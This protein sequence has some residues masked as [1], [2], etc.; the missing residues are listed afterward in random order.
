MTATFRTF[1]FV[2][3]VFIS[4]VSPNAFAADPAAATEGQ[5][6]LEK[7]KTILSSLIEQT[8]KERGVPSISIALVR[9]D[10]IVWK[11]AFGY[12]NVRTKTPA[13]PETMYN[14][15]STFKAVTATAI[16]QLAE[17]GKFNLDDPVNRYLG[18]TP[19][20]DRIQSEKPVT[21]THVLSHWSGLT[22]WP[23]R[24]EA[25]MKSVWASEVP[26]TLEQ[27]IPELYS[28]RPPEAK[29][30][31]NN[32]GYGLA[33][34]LLER[35]S[36]LQYE[37]YITEHVFKPLGVTTPHPVYPSPEMVEL[38]ALPYD[39]A[40]SGTEPH[41]APQVHTQVYPAGNAY[42][43]P[44]G[45]A[46]FLGAHINGGVFQGQR[47]LSPTSVKQ[48]HEPRFGGNYGFGFRIKKTPGGSTL[49][50]HT[51]RLPG[52]SSMMLGDVDAHVGVYYMANAT[53][54]AA[55]IADAA[56]VLLRGE[57]YPVEDRKF[58]EVDTKVLERYVGSYQAGQNVFTI[59][60][61]GE[62]LVVQKNNNKKKG[63]LLA[64]TPTSFFL[65]GDPATLTFETNS[66]RVV[67]RMVIFEADW[68]LTS[69]NRR[70]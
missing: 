50:R 27:L 18:D 44:E 64:E 45:M 29:F 26:R 6:D 4:T 65:K 58:I 61:E 49:I 42:L 40:E 30:E 19:V 34:L 25:A 10:S 1:V 7:T 60:R 13:T 39:L 32:Y 16:M 67:D 41:P 54:V 2:A 9:G 22:S 3:I 53:D 17:Q 47:I 69:A 62:N 68:Q 63:T 38:M 70:K 51:G 37:K 5:F 57:T 43:P 11:A 23:G 21:F 15:A 12:A 14:A 66:S 35:I 33:G 20:R 28:I 55:E 48:M 52:M 31:Y 46:R 8:L 56:I 59:T 24:G 36:G